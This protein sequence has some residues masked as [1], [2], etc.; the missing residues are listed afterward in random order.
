MLEA[1]DS[2][3]L[4]A[5][6]KRVHFSSLLILFGSFFLFLRIVAFS[7][8]NLLAN[9]FAYRQLT[10]WMLDLFLMKLVEAGSLLEWRDE[11]VSLTRKRKYRELGDVRILWSVGGSVG[12]V[13]S[14]W[15]VMPG[16]QNLQSTRLILRERATWSQLG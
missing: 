14:R 5:L 9:Q 2:S 10:L 7:L 6:W 1:E 4:Y 15:N 13:V 12:A 11:I 16:G 8:S 3:F